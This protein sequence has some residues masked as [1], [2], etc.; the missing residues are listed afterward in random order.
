[1]RGLPQ[2]SVPELRHLKQDKRTREEVRAKTAAKD[3]SSART[4]QEEPSG[5]QTV[6]TLWLEDN[7]RNEVSKEAGVRKRVALQGMRN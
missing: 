3:K 1:M 6:T 2:E 7:G 4:E 5:R